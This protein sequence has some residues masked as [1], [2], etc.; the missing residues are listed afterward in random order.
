M[1]QVRDVGKNGVVRWL[2][3]TAGGLAIQ[4]MCVWGEITECSRVKD[5][6]REKDLDMTWKG[7]AV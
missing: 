1:G 7:T 4:Y 5:H 3:A 6:G 2:L